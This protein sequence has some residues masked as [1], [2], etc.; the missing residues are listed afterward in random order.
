VLLLLSNIVSSPSLYEIIDEHAYHRQCLDFLVSSVL[1]SVQ[2]ENILGDVPNQCSTSQSLK[3]ADV[4]VIRSKLFNSL[5][6]LLVG[7]VEVVST[8]SVPSLLFF[9]R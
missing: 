2:L 6:F 7:D 5:D 4:H 3:L 1:E 9:S 8:F